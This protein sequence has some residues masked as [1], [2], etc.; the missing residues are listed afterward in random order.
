M[1]VTKIK[2]KEPYKKEFKKENIY[3]HF[4]QYDT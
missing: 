3:L 4:E 2:Q 1:I